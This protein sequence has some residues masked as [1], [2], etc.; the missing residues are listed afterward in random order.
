MFCLQILQQNLKVSSLE[1]VEQINIFR[2]Q[3]REIYHSKDE[4]KIFIWEMGES[5]FSNTNYY[6][7]IRVGADASWEIIR[8]G[9]IYDSRAA[10]IKI[11]TA[12]DLPFSTRISKLGP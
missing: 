6:F 1:L 9:N 7:S 5:R 2:K 11:A 12:L 8:K 10:V 4:D 3:E